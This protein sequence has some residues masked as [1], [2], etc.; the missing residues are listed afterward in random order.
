MRKRKY[1]RC[2]ETVDVEEEQ[3]TLILLRVEVKP[4]KIKRISVV[5]IH[6][7]MAVQSMKRNEQ[8]YATH[9]E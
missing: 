3:N 8:T 9:I 6:G 5:I 1:H 2:P 4:Q 7:G